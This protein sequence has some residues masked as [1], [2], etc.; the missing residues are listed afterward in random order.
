MIDQEQ[1]EN[2]ANGDAIMSA[3]CVLPEQAEQARKLTDEVLIAELRRRG[4]LTTVKAENKSHMHDVQSGYPVLDQLVSAYELAGMAAATAACD[5]GLSPFN[6]Y[7]TDAQ[8]LIRQTDMFGAVIATPKSI[9]PFFHS[10][11]DKQFRTIKVN[12]TVL[13]AGV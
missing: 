7:K 3:P 4:R 10:D 11:P 2:W 12:L 8:G 5:K 9:R 13:K 6:T 1:I